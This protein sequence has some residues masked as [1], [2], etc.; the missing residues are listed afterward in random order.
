MR[1]RESERDQG[2]AQNEQRP[3]NE[4]EWVLEGPGLAQNEL[5]AEH[6]LSCAISLWRMNMAKFP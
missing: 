5:D 1:A 4:T 2:A 6:A 3:W